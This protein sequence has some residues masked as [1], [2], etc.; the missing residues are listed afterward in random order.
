MSSEA[1]RELPPGV[2]DALY[3]Q[4]V[5]S[6]R[7]GPLFN[8]HSYPTKINVA[9]VVPFIVTHTRP[10]DL[11]FDGFAGSGVTGLA[12]SLCGN[13]DPGLKQSTEVILGPVAWGARDCVLYDLS[14]LATFISTTLLNPPDPDQFVK[15]AREVLAALDADWGWLYTAL[16]NDSSLGKIRYTLWTD[17][18][19]CP[20]CGSASTYW[21]LAVSLSPPTMASQVTCSACHRDFDVASAGRLTEDYWD[22]L[23]NRTH[24][25][26]VRTPV[27]V[28]GRTARS[29]WRRPIVEGDLELIERVEDTPIPSTVPIVPMLATED[30]RW[31]ELHR[32]GYHFG[33]THLHHFY[34]RRNL[35]AIASAW[36]ATEAYPEQIRN[37][38]RFWISSYNATH[39]TLMT[40]VVC[41]RRARDLVV[42]SAQP[43]TLYIGSLPVEKNV[44][45]GLRTKLKPVAAAFLKMYSRDGA[46]SVHCASS[47]NVNL[48]GSSVDY[49]FTDP[50]F[51]D[52]I[53]YSEVNFINEA[54]LG[55][56]TD[57]QEEAIISPYQGKTVDDY[58]SLLARAFAE[59]FR[60]LKPGRYM[61]VVFHST[62]PAIWDAL[63]A[64]WE[65][66][67]FR[68]VRSSILDK[69]QASFKQTTTEG[70]V[71]GDPVILL[72]KPLGLD[73]P[74]KDVQEIRDPWE[75]IAQ[76]LSMLDERSTGVDE[77]TRQRLF[78]YLVTFYLERE[79]SIPLDAST[80]FAELDRRFQ[81]QG[82]HYYLR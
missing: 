14:G 58:R 31:G 18:P 30:A 6:T 44:F 28:Y 75:V 80:F 57:P 78:S 4:P 19:I 22:D 71:R 73:S 74:G 5:S 46:I 43:A 9:A 34:T 61:T 70:A 15:A 55:R 27:F 1:Y 77:R 40:R 7:S 65:S 17:H 81:R 16:D 35:V 64:A 10:G 38:L 47:L 82:D 11:I 52:N 69:T 53:Q 49:I 32:A 51:G 36:Q 8:A 68:M 63:R 25:R 67:G 42:T 76:R 3:G 12:A 45:A 50:P 20:H 13:S 39:S 56:I 66:A 59:A 37:A 2:L 21:D 62:R 54:W 72:Q 33:V 60:I 29:S 79:Q 24:S 23:L 41:K 26:R 48:A